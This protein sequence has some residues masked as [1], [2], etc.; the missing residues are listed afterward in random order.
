MYQKYHKKCF[1][2]FLNHIVYTEGKQV[3]FQQVVILGLDAENLE[4]YQ[5]TQVW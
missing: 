4:F 3:I 5:L 2:H 1:I